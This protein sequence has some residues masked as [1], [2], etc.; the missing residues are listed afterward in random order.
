M[1]PK[2][3]IRN[4]ATNRK[5]NPLGRTA[6]NIYKTQIESGKSPE[7]V[8]PSGLKWVNGRIKRR[9]GP[10]NDPNIRR[11]TYDEIE[12]VQGP[13]LTYMKNIF[14]EYK[15][16]TIQIIKQYY[17]VVFNADGV[18][19]LK[20]IRK[21]TT[22]SI[23]DKFS[24]WWR[25]FSKNPSFLYH[26][27][28]NWIFDEEYNKSDNPSYRTQL[29]IMKA[30]KVGKSNYQQFFLDNEDTGEESSG[31]VS[32]HCLFKP[33]NDWA[34]CSLES[35]ESKT[36]KK[37]Y[38]RII[39]EVTKYAKEYCGGVPENKFQEICDKLTIGIQV[40]IP[41]HL[42][43]IKT[44]F[45]KYECKQKP[46]KKFKF[47]NTRLNHIDL[48][49]ISSKTDY[50]EVTQEELIEIKNQH[51]KDKFCLWKGEDHK[52]FQ[53]LTLQKVYKLTEA[54][55][56][57]KEVKEFE[58]LNNLRD[59]QI[60]HYTNKELSQ[61]LLENVNS[62]GGRMFMDSDDSSISKEDLEK[63]G[64]KHIDMKKAY[65]QGMEC[66]QYQGY[67]GKIT[68]FRECNKIMGIGI[69][70][71]ENIKN[72]PEV[73]SKLGVL[74]DDNSYSSPELEYYISLGITF[75]I[76]MGCW[77]T[78]TDIKFTPG[79]FLKDDVGL[80]H[81]CRWHGSSM[82]VSFKDTYNFDC[83]NIK[84]AELN[85]TNECSIRYNEY[86]KVGIIEYEKEQ[87]FHSSHIAGFVCSYCRISMIEQLLKFNGLEQIVAV[88]VD[89]IYFTGEVEVGSL[90][91]E[92]PLKD[93]NIYGPDGYISIVDLELP[94]N[95]PK[96]RIHNPVE[97]HTG[98]GGGGKT[99]K[100][101]IDKGLVNV[102]YVAPPW[103]LA[104][105]KTKEYNVK[106][107]VVHYLTRPGSEY[108][109]IRRYYNVLIIDE[110]SMINN[111]DKKL[112]M[113]RFKG[114]KIIF[115]GDIGYQLPPVEG[116][117]FKI[118]NLPRYEHNTN[119]RCR[120]DILQNILN[121]CRKIIGGSKDDNFPEMKKI[122]RKLG[123]VIQNKDDIDYKI[124]DL[125]I[126]KTHKNK[127]TYT[128]KYKDLEK[129]RVTENTK[130]YSNG[131]IIIGS[132]PDCRCDL[133]HSFTC[134]SIQGETATHKLF[135]DINKMVSMR[136][137]Y[138]ALSRARYF[139]QI[140]IV[141]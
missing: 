15:G 48:N 93:L 55:G 57:Q 107:N 104:R 70:R 38:T 126:C 62:N 22:E 108:L 32:S 30:N 102:L 140:I 83:E 20:E 110:I 99:H 52:P 23:P 98:Q 73:I 43:G 116:R 113:K 100:N 129:W 4:P 106:S 31:A 13:Q 130:K 39:K 42:I 69:Y 141:C 133:Q 25:N 134:H 75:D 58:E 56:Y 11:I 88:V 87:A 118:K 17:T 111:K 8:L 24:S 90:F 26:D 64:C 10:I 61:Y 115:C 112:I 82:K 47:I 45:I 14:K 132:K 101:L 123:F 89:G 74:Y 78:R 35:S 86:K 59:F 33:I 7:S 105:N 18:G 114:L 67:L 44:E 66:S 21:T 92:K 3:I 131:D 94:Q 72:I 137:I 50:E 121:N 91:R 79:M 95:L 54:E 46:Y 9:I 136:M 135:I 96:N 1:A 2:L 125:I 122:I 139:N 124:E 80:S 65:T 27:S 71:I 76:V 36:A 49:E 81:F 51:H 5:I 60:E 12:A 68:D 40:D 85:T 103:K 63:I 37:R 28:D 119:F 41:S 29:L 34:I 84:F 109:S 128:E 53:V 117:E 138:S 6:L 120:C 16:E 97:V 77:G 19:N 127:N